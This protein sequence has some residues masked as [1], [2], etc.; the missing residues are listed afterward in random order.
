MTGGANLLV[1]LVTPLELRSVESTERA[2]EAERNVLGLLESPKPLP[3]SISDAVLAKKRPAT[4][5]VP[6]E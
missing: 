1:D 2:F 3:S 5:A 4:A 6:A